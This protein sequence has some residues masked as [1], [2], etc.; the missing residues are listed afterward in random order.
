MAH[1][2]VT[3]DSRPSLESCAK[4]GVNIKQASDVLYNP[5]S[6]SLE[7]VAWPG[8]LIVSFLSS[9]QRKL[10]SWSVSGL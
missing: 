3:A 4:I 6:I 10:V 9:T 8:L 5:G 1:A 2:D 7:E